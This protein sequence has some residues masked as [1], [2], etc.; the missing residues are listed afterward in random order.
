L[1]DNDHD[2]F[3]PEHFIEKTEN[4]DYLLYADTD[5]AYL[6]YDLPFNKYDDIHQL[7]DYVQGIAR[8]LGTLYNGALEHYLCN[9]AG[10]N[11]EYNT[12]DF[13]SEVV[14]YKGFFNTKKF[15]SL[16][17]A[18]DE[19]TFFE[20]KPKLK[21]TGGQI[22]KSD[23][24]QL[25]KKLLTEVYKVIVTDINQTDIVE[26]YR[27]IFI[28]LKNKYK[29]QIRDDIAKTHF[30]SFSIPKKWG[31]TEKSIPPFVT[32]A[33]LF[34]VI[35]EDTFRPSDSFIVVKIIPDIE[36]LL[37]YYTTIDVPEDR[38]HLQRHEVATLGN[39]INVLS[40]PPL[41]S[42]EQKQKLLEQF[43]KLNIKLDYDEIVSFNIDLKLEPFEKL[44]D[45][46]T[47]M[48]AC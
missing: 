2:W 22:K 21:T 43:K 26:M 24:T 5:S 37:D 19:G 1:F 45:M 44:F 31:N 38:F 29:L 40:L 47:R 14:A 10:L 7:V 6:L 8:E 33:K 11:P 13:K 27:I 20:E 46:E 36:K 25:T 17:K 28:E 12:M 39:K 15:Y 41:M 4:D 32:G 35:M 42:E 48:K 3:L 30:A 18:W 9:F 16:A 34:N 23:V